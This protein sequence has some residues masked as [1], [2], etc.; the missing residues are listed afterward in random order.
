VGI[1]IVRELGP[2]LTALMVAARGGSGI[3]A[4]LGSM[5]VTE[6][7][8][9][10]EAMGANPIVKLVIPRV[11]VT[12]LVTPILTLIADVLGILGGMVVSVIES[13]VSTSFYLDQVKRTVEIEDV[14][15]GIGKTFFFGFLIGIISCYQGLKTSRGTEGVGNSTTLSV[16][17]CSVAVFVSDY[18]LTKVFLLF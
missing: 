10:I 14:V 5:T 9:A 11:L 7:V 16:V 4:E 12:T 6:Q 1:A 8:L 13:G 15:S 18:F 3:A 17:I 2:V